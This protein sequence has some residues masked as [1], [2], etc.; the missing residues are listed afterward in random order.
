M[1]LTLAACDRW[2]KLDCVSGGWKDAYPVFHGRYG[3][4][5]K[6]L[7]GITLFDCNN[8]SLFDQVCDDL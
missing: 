8:S 7:T 6:D 4:S 1:T 5:E 2:A 3:S